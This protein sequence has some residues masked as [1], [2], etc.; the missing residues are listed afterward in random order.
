MNSHVG[1]GVPYTV[2]VNTADSYRDCWEPFFVLFRRYWPD[3]QA[4][5]ILNTENALFEDPFGQ[6]ES[7]QVQRP[8][9]ARLPWS[10]CVRRC[11]ERVETPLVLY[12][13]EDYFL[14]ELVDNS[15]LSALASYAMNH[16]EVSQIGLTAFGAYPPFRETP[17]PRLWLVGARAR[18]R[19]SLQAAFWRVQSL[20]S[21]LRP[22]ENG[23]MFEIYGTRRSWRRGDTFLTVNRELEQQSRVFPYRHAG[24]VKGQW[25]VTVPEFFRREGISMDYNVRGF[26][27]PRPMVLEKLRT[28]RKL[29][30]R[31]SAL[32]RGFL[33]R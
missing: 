23:W 11:I 20:Q 9:E 21:Y 3:C 19:T 8:G 5:V 12:L 33:G 26:Y 25:D 14:E 18:Y 15:R 4:R 2:V 27:R 17:D 32:G 6:V 31:P 24:I 22:E 13:Q 29:L 1:T 16:P 7:A 28:L 30:A 10:E